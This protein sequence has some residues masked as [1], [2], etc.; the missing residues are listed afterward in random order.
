[1][2]VSSFCTDFT[3]FWARYIPEP[4]FFCAK[5]DKFSIN[6]R[7]CVGIFVRY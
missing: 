5:K 2:R 1:M 3:R 4:F 6:R 7:G